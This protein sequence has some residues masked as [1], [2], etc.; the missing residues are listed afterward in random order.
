MKYRHLLDEASEDEDPERRLAL[1]A[2]HQLTQDSHTAG[3]KSSMVPMNQETFE[4]VLDDARFL[5]ECVNRDTGKFIMQ[6]EGEGYKQYNALGMKSNFKKLVTL[7]LCQA[8]GTAIQKSNGEVIYY[9]NKFDEYIACNR[10][11]LTTRRTGILFGDYKTFKHGTLELNNLKTGGKAVVQFLEQS[12]KTPL[13]QIS[14]EVF[15]GK[16]VK[17]YDLKGNIYESIQLIKFSREV[18]EDSSDLD[19][20]PE[21]IEEDIV[22]SMH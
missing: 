10:E 4:M 12:S 5:S 2:C 15:D 20:S 18:V 17:H 13:G 19:V 11:N 3:R 1:I 14:G 6:M 9:L 7:K 21:A 22:N 8:G 16:G